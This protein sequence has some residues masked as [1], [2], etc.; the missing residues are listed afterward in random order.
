M[1]AKKF[2][3]KVW[4]RLNLLT[5]DEEND[6]VA[7]VS[8]VG[9]TLRNED[10]ARAVKDEGSELQYETLLDILNRADRLRVKKIQ[11]GYSILTG[12]S[13]IS[14]RVLGAWVGSLFRFDP[15]KHRITVDQTP[16]AE[17][18][19]A[20]DE[21][22]VEVLG[23]KDSGAIIGLVTDVATGKTDGT[24]TP[25]DDII[26]EGE[27]IRIAPGDG[28]GLGIFFINQTGQETPVTHRLT[29]NDPKKVIARVPLLDS[30]I[31][32]LEIRTRFSRGSVFLKETR[33]LTYSLPLTVGENS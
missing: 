13:H 24:I 5:K 32:T 2:F 19:A 11:E 9:K 30:G 12:V 18:R 1:S 33:T 8:T 29:Q 21:V 28:A 20:L 14:P 3:W 7:E 4:L 25:D 6:Y 27:K 16:S 26:I 15:E 23:V 22:G 17:L 31:Y 10:I